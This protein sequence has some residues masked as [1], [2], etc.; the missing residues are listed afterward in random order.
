LRQLNFEEESIKM[1]ELIMKRT[2]TETGVKFEAEGRITMANERYFDKVLGDA[3][4][5]GCTHIILNMQSVTMLTSVGIRIILKTFKSCMEKE[6]KF[7]IETPSD[8]VKNVL[9]LSALQQMLV[10]S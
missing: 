2:K 4:E 8:A 6:G 5:E 10:E 1:N 9:G 3:L 7:Q